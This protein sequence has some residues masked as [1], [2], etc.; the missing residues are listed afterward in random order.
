[1]ETQ[2]PT[3][4]MRIDSLISYFDAIPNTSKAFVIICCLFSFF[5]L[6]SSPNPAAT[7]NT[8]TYP[9]CDVT[10][11]KTSNKG[12]SACNTVS[13]SSNCE[14]E[15]QPKW[16]ILKLLNVIAVIGLL[17]SFFWFA[18]NASTYIN[19]SNALLKFMA[20]WSGFLCYFFGFFGISF[21]DV[22]EL[23]RGSSEEEEKQRT[24]ECQ[25]SLFVH[26]QLPVHPPAS[27]TPVCSDNLKI[28]TDKPSKPTTFTPS[29]NSTNTNQKN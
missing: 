15:P 10:K 27:C 5:L 13:K 9:G 12:S 1:M 11:A 21:I 26:K 18:S 4:G 16:H 6:N 19:D 28:S 2:I 23:E 25:K 7:L 8:S 3:I 20:L 24:N 17:T 14:S 29:S 22:E